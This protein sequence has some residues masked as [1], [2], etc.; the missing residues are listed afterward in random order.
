VQKV[1]VDVNQS[2]HVLDSYQ[3]DCNHSTD[4]V[5]SHVVAKWTC[6]FCSFVNINT[7]N[8]LQEQQQP[9]SITN[10]LCE[11]CDEPFQYNPSIES[12][13]Q[14]LPKSLKRPLSDVTNTITNTLTT[15]K[16]IKPLIS[17][18]LPLLSPPLCN[19]RNICSLARVRKTGPTLHRL[20]WSCNHRSKKC[21]YF[22]WADGLFPKCKNHN[23]QKEIVCILRRVLKDGPNNGRYFF[24]C[25][26]VTTVPSSSSSSSS[27]G[28]FVWADSLDSP[29]IACSESHSLKIPL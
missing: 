12:S 20:F 24:T 16:N 11:V 26:S 17:S 23:D 1:E 13:P 5:K 8:H 14:I 15:S 6:S 4:T 25:P 9:Y 28:T 22:H 19:C 29:L 27:C 10:L 2:H 21:S 18:N 7:P 3:S